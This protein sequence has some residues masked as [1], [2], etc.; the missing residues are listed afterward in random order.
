MCVTARVGGR[1]VMKPYIPGADQERLTAEIAN[2][3]GLDTYVEGEPLVS[4]TRLGIRVPADQ[5]K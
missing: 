1:A 2:L 3:A 4:L 5:M